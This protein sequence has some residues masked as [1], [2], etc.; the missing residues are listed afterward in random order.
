VCQKK[1]CLTWY[2]P[3]ELPPVFVMGE[4]P[5]WMPYHGGGRRLEYDVRMIF[6]C[7]IGYQSSVS[8]VL[9]GGCWE[10]PRGK[11]QNRWS[12]VFLDLLAPCLQQRWCERRV[13][14]RDASVDDDWDK[15]RLLTA[16]NQ[17]TPAWQPEQRTLSVGKWC[18][19]F[20]WRILYVATR[21]KPIGGS[22]K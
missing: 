21:P 4:A 7:C 22:K 8:Q 5:V 19:D 2:R 1:C 15:P 11:A 13:L 14:R 10:K 9:I 18:L 6:E 12:A 17:V 20:D 3:C 16:S